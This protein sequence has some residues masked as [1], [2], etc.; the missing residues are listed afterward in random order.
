MGKG[1]IVRKVM[2]SAYNLGQVSGDY[3]FFS[4]RPF[5]NTAKFG[6]DSWKQVTPSR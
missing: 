1:D 2:L 5:N 3:V 4:Y 6:N